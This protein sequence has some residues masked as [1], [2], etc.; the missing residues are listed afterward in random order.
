MR[1]NE[2]KAVTN[3]PDQ[4]GLNAAGE[5]SKSCVPAVLLERDAA[6]SSLARTFDH[7]GFHFRLGGHRFFTKVQPHLICPIEQFDEL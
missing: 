2:K 6:V 1:D 5:F 4:A 7:E 3:G